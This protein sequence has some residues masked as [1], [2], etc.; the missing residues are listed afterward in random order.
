MGAN[1]T[2]FVEE[3]SKGGVTKTNQ[4]A[5][6][7]SPP[8]SLNGLASNYG[9]NFDDLAYRIQR[10]TL[11]SRQMKPIMQKSVFRELRPLPVGYNTLDD[12]TM[13]IVL[14]SDL[15]ER[16][17]FL[18]WQN[19][20]FNEGG[21]PSYI[22]TVVGDMQVTTIGDRRDQATHIFE[23][24]WPMM[25]GDIELSAESTELSMMNVVWQYKNWYMSD[26][27]EWRDKMKSYSDGRTSAIGSGV[28]GIGDGKSGHVLGSTD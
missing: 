24:C 1:I 18:A 22:D 3:I 12:V 20:I 28:S 15:K 4:Y 25:V 17:F 8:S 26:D 2:S 9:I 6:K 23:S 5:V 10:V 27:K 19:R 7:I 21:T 16:K 11:P 14:S 13:Q